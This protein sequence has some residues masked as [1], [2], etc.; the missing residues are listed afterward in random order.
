M[1]DPTVSMPIAVSPSQIPQRSAAASLAL[2]KAWPGFALAGVLVLLELS[3]GSLTG[4]MQA[5]GGRP[6]SQ[7]P[8]TLVWL[9]N[10]TGPTLSL[11]VLAVLNAL[12]YVAGMV[13]WFW[14]VYRIHKILAGAT[15]SSYPITPAK[16]VGYQF[17]PF[18]CIAWNFKWPRQ[19][20]AFVNGRSPSAAM[21]KYWTGVFLLFASIL[22]SLDNGLQLLALSGIGL[23]LV[24]KLARADLSA[25]APQ[26]AAAPSLGLTV[27]APMAGLRRP[28]PAA[29]FQRWMT[30][31]NEFDWSKAREL[32][33]SL[34]ACSGATFGFLACY[35]LW[36]TIQQIKARDFSFW[37]L[38]VI[39]VIAF[40]L[41]QFVEPLF[42]LLKDVFSGKRAEDEDESFFVRS[43]LFL[44]FVSVVVASHTLLEKTHEQFP[45]GET[46]FVAAG[47]AIFF[48]VLTYAL[49]RGTKS[50]LKAAFKVVGGWLSIA[51]VI[52]VVMQSG[53]S[54]A[55]LA[56]WA[57]GPS[58]F[59]AAS[60]AAGSPATIDRGQAINNV[61]SFVTNGPV[62][63]EE[64][65]AEKKVGSLSVGSKIIVPF[66]G[67]LFAVL[68]GVFVVAQRHWGP[69]EMAVCGFVSAIVA[70]AFELL[71]HVQNIHVFACV[72]AA[73]GW[74]VAVLAFCEG[75]LLRLRDPLHALSAAHE[76][77]SPL[78]KD[79]QVR[80]AALV[81]IFALFIATC[82][83][84]AHAPA[85]HIISSADSAVRQYHQP[86]PDLTEQ[87]I[88]LDNDLVVEG[89]P[90][91]W[92]EASESSP[93]DTYT[94]HVQR[95]SLKVIH[96]KGEQDED[97]SDGY[98]F[99][100]VQG[101]LRV[102][103]AES[104]VTLAPATATVQPNTAVPLT[105]T[106]SSTL[107]TPTGTV[108]FL[109]GGTSV[110]TSA[111]SNGAALFP[112]GLSLGQHLI[113]ARYNAEDKHF[114]EST[115][116]AAEVS[117]IDGHVAVP[118]A[119]SIRLTSSSPSASPNTPVTFTAKLQYE[120]YTPTGSVTFKDN[121]IAMATEELADGIGS[122]TTRELRPGTHTITA[123]Y[124]G[125][126]A[127]NSL[128]ETIELAMVQPLIQVFPA[129]APIAVRTI[130]PVDSATARVGQSVR[131][132]LQ[133]P[134]AMNRAPA[135][136]RVV[137]VDPAGKMTGHSS[138]TLELE[139]VTIAGRSYPVRT[140]PVERLGPSKSAD[141]MKKTGVG[142]AIGG[143]VGGIF[144]HGKGAAIGAASGAGA[145]AAAATFTSAGPA[146]VPS[147]TLLIFRLKSSLNLAG[148]Q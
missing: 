38:L 35:G 109:D 8:K 127:S 128:T 122:F 44:A 49:I 117:V 40:L 105:A 12:V 29:L 94:I 46:I 16:A 99:I 106:V 13:Y 65:R 2:P 55:L 15:D 7:L 20:A 148:G 140:I 32:R 86:N 81:V 145:G 104:A 113:T 30:A 141:A 42:D 88:T 59:R 93:P 129:G 125:G 130:D 118:A 87:P 14:S 50:G 9:T 121:S 91:I 84:F 57:P 146:R 76:Q 53:L 143:A 77:D 21:S 28:A 19:V 82:V 115:S 36:T 137:R 98:M 33:L 85:I 25:P 10:P 18:Y 72:W 60:A 5:V 134:L 79:A 116:D 67:F 1:A 3:F 92:T 136:L 22:G 31:A 97:W 54:W 41:W 70:M 58:L 78:R 62:G 90:V 66:S 23:Y 103:P 73:T 126:G 138:V 63:T 89:S 111:I 96:K 26:V 100:P 119:T 69:R 71:R 124:S 39:A 64:E 68:F 6:V 120:G 102:L 114:Q 52:G 48:G 37:D 45:N 11:S 132:S 139:S 123:E 108:T 133:S 135:M 83:A 75:D 51:L 142:A 34:A 80:I 56:T 24:R 112:T 74:C 110:G 95:G 147:E 27:A 17:I 47:L 101:E 107:G 61:G 131:A 144:G 4:L 43:I